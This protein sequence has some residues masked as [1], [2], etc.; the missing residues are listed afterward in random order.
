M[1]GLTLAVSSLLFFAWLSEEVM[2]NDTARFDASVRS[3][4]Y[5][6][7]TPLLTRAMHAASAVG[8][9]LAVGLPAAL[10]SALFW[11]RRRRNEALVLMVT[12]VGATI[13]T[14]VL[15]LSFRRVRPVPFYGLATPDSFSFPSGH[16]LTALCFW[17]MLAHLVN[18]HISSL[19]ART[20]IRAIAV[21]II[22]SIGFSRIYLG[23]HYP[24]DVLAGFAAASVWVAIVGG[25]IRRRRWA[26]Y[27]K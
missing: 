11:I 17:G 10:A 2:E 13:L 9:P 7:S 20:G 23:V 4:I 21:I 3:L 15:K 8:S 12:V 25:T 26:G 1:A 14:Q 5:R 19:G 16:A 6:N 27:R 22:L 18:S 24:S